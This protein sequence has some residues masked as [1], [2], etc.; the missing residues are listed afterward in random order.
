MA[1][2]A[3]T[4]SE[5]DS[6]EAGPVR[7]SGRTIPPATGPRRAGPPPV[8][9]GTKP[10]A[11]SSQ[12]PSAT[13]MY[14]Y[15]ATSAQEL[16]ISDG[17]HLTIIEEDNDSSGW[18]KARDE[19]GAE[20]LVPASYLTITAPPAASAS[21]PSAGRRAPP[22]R[23]AAGGA[24]SVQGVG[25]FVRA[26]YDYAAQEDNELTLSEGE[27]VELTSTGYDFGAGWCE[28]V[29]AGKVGVFPANYV[30]NI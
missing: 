23:P 12:H 21:R 24:G 1:A 3:T 6:S 2:G 27:E 15:E 4:P 25:R 10:S 20:G 14:D 30:E 8:Q 7:S 16:S 18:V 19:H 22:P 28:G 26:L 9:R 11:T 17:D 5:K 13:A 29:K